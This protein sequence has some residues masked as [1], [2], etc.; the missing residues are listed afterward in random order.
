MINIAKSQYFS[1]ITCQPISWSFA[2]ELNPFEKESSSMSSSNPFPKC[3]NVLK[4]II[5]TEDIE[6]RVNK[7]PAK[8]ILSYEKVR[9]RKRAIGVIAIAFLIVFTVLAFLGQISFIVWVLADLVVAAVANLLFR[10][11]ARR[12]L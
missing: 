3:A 8:E 5:E 12:P 4:H 9:N 11:V 7:T 1:P 10:R 2:A 6:V